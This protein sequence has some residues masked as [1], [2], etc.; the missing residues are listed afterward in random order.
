MLGAIKT[1]F[2]EESLVTLKGSLG[3]IVGFGSVTHFM[4]F[5]GPMLQ[6]ISSIGGLI[7]LILSIRYKIMQIKKLK[8]ENNAK[9]RKDITD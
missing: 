4:D 1:I 6:I 2:T 9:I 7:V 3:A 8:Q 5:L